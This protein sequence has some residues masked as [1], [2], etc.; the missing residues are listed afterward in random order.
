MFLILLAWLT[1]AISTSPF[2]AHLTYRYRLAESEFLRGPQGQQDER[3]W[4]AGTYHGI[5]VG[6]S[7]ATE[8]FQKWG[9]PKVIGHWDW[10]NPKNPKFRLYHFDSQEELSGGIMVNV[11]MKTGKVDFIELALDELTFSKAIELFG[12]DY[13]ETWYKFC[14]CDLGD[15]APVFESPDGNLRYLEY[16]SRGIAMGVDYRGNTKMITSI[17]FVDKPIGFKSA[18]GC[19][20]FPECRPKRTNIKRKRS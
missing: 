7:T 6:K 17:Q 18:R 11:E 20:K 9:K 4:K 3:Q 10:D 12:E 2:C 8:L 1:V 16:W 14:N 5:T 19:E 15:G 13:I